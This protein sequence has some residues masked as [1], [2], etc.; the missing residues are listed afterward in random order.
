MFNDFTVSDFLATEDISILTDIL[1]RKKL[2]KITGYLKELVPADQDHLKQ[3]LKNSEVSGN[4][5]RSFLI[6]LCRNIIITLKFDIKIRRSKK[7]ICLCCF[8]NNT[9]QFLSNF[10]TLICCFIQKTFPFFRKPD[11]SSLFIK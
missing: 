8:I 7:T 11:N 10:H 4:T 1:V 6:N 3:N 5:W 9:L 2:G